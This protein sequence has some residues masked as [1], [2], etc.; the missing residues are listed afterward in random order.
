MN[1]PTPQQ[2]LHGLEADLV[3]VLAGILLCLISSA[4]QKRS[5]R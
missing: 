2:I 3:L 1:L 5:R 4:L